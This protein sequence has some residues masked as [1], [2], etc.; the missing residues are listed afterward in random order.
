MLEAIIRRLRGYHA[1]GNERA[2]VAVEHKGFEG[3]IS[4]TINRKISA[5]LARWLY[6]TNPHINPNSMTYFFTA[7]GI[8]GAA[9]YT[10]NE[11]GFA[12]VGGLLTQASSILDG[13]DGDYARYLPER[14]EE[15]KHFGATLDMVCD[16]AINGAVIAGMGYYA[17]KN[18]GP[19][20]GVL[21]SLTLALNYTATWSRH[22]VKNKIRGGMDSIRR[23]FTGLECLG[24]RD[25]AL[26]TLCIGSIGE[27][28][29]YVC[30]EL[31]GIPLAAS[32]AVASSF[33]MTSIASRLCK[34]KRYPTA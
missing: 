10:F 28:V 14:S 12:I 27:G 3:I 17:Y 1:I 16:R 25:V 29:S 32:L 19:V 31:Q 24:G 15:E 30:P 13:V 11:P 2:D 23:F 33:S 20:G 18:L 8:A 21:G 22:Y 34:L 26:F 7:I 6:T 5:P 9:A 4:R